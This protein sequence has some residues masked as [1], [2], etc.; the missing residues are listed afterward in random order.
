MRRVEM[1]FDAEFALLIQEDNTCNVSVELFT[2]RRLHI[3]TC[4]FVCLDS[5]LS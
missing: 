5:R 2:E 4:M 3:S 1:E